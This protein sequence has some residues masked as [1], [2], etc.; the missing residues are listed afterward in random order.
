MKRATIAAWAAFAAL[1]SFIPLQTVHAVEVCYESTYTSQYTP[2]NGGQGLYCHDSEGIF[3]ITMGTIVANQGAGVLGTGD[4]LYTANQS[5]AGQFS[6]ITCSD[7]TGTPYDY[8]ATFNY[9]QVDFKRGTTTFITAYLTAVQVTCPP[10]PEEGCA[11]PFVDVGGGVCECP[12]GTTYNADTNTCDSDNPC[13]ELADTTANILVELGASSVGSP[14]SHNGC[15]GSMTY[16]SLDI[17]VDT[18][19]GRQFIE[20]T[21]TY[22]G[23]SPT[24]GT[25][26]GAQTSGDITSEPAQSDPT[27]TEISSTLSQ[28]TQ[29]LP[30]GTTVE[31]TVTQ[32]IQQED[33]YI[34]NEAT[35]ETLTITEMGGDTVTTTE[36]TTTTTAPDGSST[37]DTNTTTEITTNVGDTYIVT[38]EN[39]TTTITN[40]GGTS[41][42]TTSNTT[43]TASY[44]SNG[45]L[46][47]ESSTSDTDPNATEN[48]G[49]APS[50]VTEMEGAMD[51]YSGQITDTHEAELEG[52]AVGMPTWS[53]GDG[54]CY[55]IPYDFKHLGGQG[56]FDSHCP[57]YD[58]TLRPVLEWLLYAFTVYTLFGIWREATQGSTA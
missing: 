12:E 22:D 33:S 34:R 10:P 32:T 20:G 50:G 18:V 35:G 19:D 27:Y 57:Y 9:D 1:F 11:T 3:Q 40:V 26:V 37:V 21:F 44:D 25:T 36:T 23:T 52:L 38:N 48:F 45:N 7:E 13:A 15:G 5:A 53:F 29:T 46:I 54:Q 2:Y 43:G 56:V 39:G 30:D 42:T 4:S 16:D 31:T 51:G 55:G 58:T 49:D 8:A 47:S 41:S 17:V 6:N 28:D 24:E 14:I